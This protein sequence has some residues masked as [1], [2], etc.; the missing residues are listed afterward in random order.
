MSF[1]LFPQSLPQSMIIKLSS[2]DFTKKVLLTST[3]GEPKLSSKK[4]VGGIY[5]DVCQPVPISLLTS[6][7]LIKTNDKC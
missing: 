1:C 6:D 3:K 5:F 4:L 7:F 2:S